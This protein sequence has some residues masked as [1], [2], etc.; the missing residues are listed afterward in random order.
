MK[1]RVILMLGMVLPA[2]ASDS[3]K[4]DATLNDVSSK[5]GGS[6]SDSGVYA[7]SQS[8]DG[9]GVDGYDEDTQ[10][11]DSQ[12]ADSQSDMMLQPADY[13]LADGQ[14]NFSVNG[15]GLSKWEGARVTV[16]ALENDNNIQPTV[17]TRRLLLSETIKN[18]TFSISCAYAI[19]KN[20]YYP[21][22]A[23][24]IDVDGDGHCSKADVAYQMQLYGWN[25]D[26]H[27]EISGEEFF[28]QL[29]NPNFTIGVPIGS[30]AP[31]F[32]SAYFL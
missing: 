28:T 9:F 2:C 32:C 29:S 12:S 20:S 10:A 1:L 4:S 16:A 24:Y 18:G 30:D 22:Y 26:E 25:K 17:V 5:D 27:E 6:K 3:Q 11:S 31:D 8:V 7:D 19:N 14:F 21:S 23:L 13:C 15:K